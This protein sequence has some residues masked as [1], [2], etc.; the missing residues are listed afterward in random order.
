MLFYCWHTMTYASTSSR[1]SKMRSRKRWRIWAMTETMRFRQ[2][3]HSYAQP[4]SI[5]KNASNRVKWRRVN[6]R[7]NCRR[8]S[9]WRRMT[10]DST[11]SC[12]GCPSP[13][14]N[15]CKAWYKCCPIHGFSIISSTATKIASSEWLSYIS[16]SEIWT[17]C[18]SILTRQVSSCES[19]CVKAVSRRSIT[20]TTDIVCC[21]KATDSWHTK[22]TA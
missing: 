10:T 6:C 17:Y 14:R 3:A 4:K 7:R 13:N 2:S 11:I 8:C 18:G 15:I 22:T 9:R 5:G 21:C 16:R 12:L 19:S 1:K 20:S